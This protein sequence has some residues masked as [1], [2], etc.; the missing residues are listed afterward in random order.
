MATSI[1]VLLAAAGATVLLRDDGASVA[2]SR[3]APTTT[4]VRPA[5]SAPSTEA[6]PTGADDE[7]PA[8]TSTSAV[9]P[10][11]TAV[12]ETSPPAPADHAVSL[13]GRTFESVSAVEGSTERTFADGAAVRVQFE[14]T[15]TGDVVR[16]RISCNTAGATVSVSADRLSVGE[17]GSSAAGCDPE[18]EAEDAWIGSFFGS[19]P[20]WAL[21]G[22]R[23]VLRSGDTAITLDEV[24]AEAFGP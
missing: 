16:W 21:D 5:T 11:S 13:R 24:P 4:A 22:S 14:G 23:L 17:I 3:T 10:P 6:A 15:P 2:T 20:G 9:A 1:A 12:A 8:T 19:D 7:A 18:K